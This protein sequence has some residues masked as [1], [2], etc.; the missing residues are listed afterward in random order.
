LFF[1][2]PA[3]F[4]HDLAYLTVSKDYSGELGRFVE[5]ARPF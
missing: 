5:K 1:I 2:D 3:P 4:D